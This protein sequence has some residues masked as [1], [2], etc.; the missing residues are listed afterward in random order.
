MPPPIPAPPPSA[1]RVVLLTAGPAVGSSLPVRVFAPMTAIAANP[2]STTIIAS[3]PASD[4]PSTPRL[5]MPLPGCTRKRRA[6]ASPSARPRAR[7]AANA[8]WAPTRKDGSPHSR[9]PMD[10]LLDD[11]RLGALERE[12]RDV[13]TRRAVLTR[14]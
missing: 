14:L 13:V 1:R 2:P 3:T 5:R 6:R 7:Q 4:A 9:V 8:Q 10:A 11:Q 12:I